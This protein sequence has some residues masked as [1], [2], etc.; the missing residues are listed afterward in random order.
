M[1]VCWID[2]FC[3]YT[4]HRGQIVSDAGTGKHFSRSV[5]GREKPYE[6]EV[7]LGVAVAAPL[8]MTCVSRTAWTT[9]ERDA[10]ED[11]PGEPIGRRTGFDDDL[12]PGRP[13][14][15]LMATHDQQKQ[16]LSL[17]M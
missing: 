15:G 10:N 16:A 5:S 12:A 14:D 3:Q 7:M 17:F 6:G 9:A 4:R 13:P 1:S 2:V 8:R 11:P